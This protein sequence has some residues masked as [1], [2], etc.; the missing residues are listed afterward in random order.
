M[1][2][3]K[4][5]TQ[6]HY[7]ALLATMTAIQSREGGAEAAAPEDA[8]AVMVHNRALLRNKRLMLAYMCV[9]RCSAFPCGCVWTTLRVL[10]M[11]GAALTRSLPYACAATRAWGASRRCGGR[12]AAGCRLTCP[13]RSRPP[14]ATSSQPTTGAP[15]SSM[16]AYPYADVSCCFCCRLLG[17]YMGR[18][19]VGLNL[20]LDPSPPK[21]QKV[22][23]RCL[24]DAGTIYTRDGEITLRARSVHY[25]WR[26]EAQPLIAEG[27]LQKVNDDL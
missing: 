1:R 14:S 16:H 12:W 21:G 23:V 5:E 4:E 18:G 25:M 6:E 15:H 20:T 26:D 22:E 8:A 9:P 27:V 13:P 2:V 10:R 7:R 17:A 24:V 11:R 3:V 19:G